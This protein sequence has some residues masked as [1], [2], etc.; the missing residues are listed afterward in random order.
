MT[1]DV[2]AR[3]RL[4]FPLWVRL[5]HRFNLLFLSLLVRSGIEILAAH[6]KLHV[7]ARM[8]GRRNAYQDQPCV[9]PVQCR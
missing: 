3:T 5:A 7:R 6:P 4:P 9:A 2:L 1:H 8:V